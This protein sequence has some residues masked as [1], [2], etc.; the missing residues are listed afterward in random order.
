VSLPNEAELRE[1]LGPH[2]RLD[3]PLA[4]YTSSRI[5]GTADGLL[6]VRSAAELAGAAR[7]LWALGQPFLVLGAG[8]N[9]LISDQGCRE[10][11][12]INRAKRVTFGSTSGNFPLVHCESGAS[13]GL[14]AR[15][16]VQRGWAGLEWA[17]GIPG[18]VGGA[19]VGNAGASGGDI[20]S[21]LYMAEILQHLAQ[22]KAGNGHAGPSDASVALFSPVELSLVYRSSR[23]KQ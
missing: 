2:L 14:V 6:E 15:Q 19:I 12:L 8:S 18:T 10:I 11:V 23:L 5:G 21:S 9:V 13:L 1:G 7:T 16:T 4:R 17:V 20:A 3:V 22:G